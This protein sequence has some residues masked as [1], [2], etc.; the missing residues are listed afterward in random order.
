VIKLPIGIIKA[1][2][3][4]FRVKNEIKLLEAEHTE[5]KDT[6]TQYMS[7]HSLTSI[8][9][10][11]A[12]AIYSVREGN[13]IDPEGYWEALQG[14]VDKLLASVTV[15]MD[16]KGDKMG[17]RSYLGEEDIISISNPV[18]IPV[19]RIK[20]LTTQPIKVDVPKRRGR[21]ATV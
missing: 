15:R 4:L 9:G 2:D 12:Q 3:E 1:V 16:P 7:D 10:R 19:L 5:L 8:D 17:A 11:K 14:N 13:E 20:K 21:V 18:E 6:I